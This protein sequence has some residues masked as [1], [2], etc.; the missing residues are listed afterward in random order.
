MPTNE[1]LIKQMY[2][3]DLASKK[4]QLQQSYETADSEF[5]AAKEKNAQVTDQNLT[6]TAV[7][8]QKAAKNM[9]E[10]H[11]AQGLSSG[12]RAQARLSLENQA[13]ANM[14]ALRAAQQ[15]SDAEIERQ[16]ALL[17][18]DY[19]AAIAQAQ[20]DNDLQKAQALYEQA[21]KAEAALLA[22]QEAAAGLMAQ[23]GDYSGY[24]TLYGMT[25]AQIAQLSNAY[26]SSAEAAAQEAQNAEFERQWKLAKD[27]AEMGDD[28]YMNA[29]LVAAGMKTEEPV[30]PENPPRD[31]YTVT[32]RTGN[33]WVAIGNSRMTNAELDAAIASGQVKRVYDDTNK[34][35]AYQY[36]HPG[37]SPNGT[38]VTGN[39]TEGN[40]QG[41]SSQQL[42]DGR[43]DISGQKMTAAELIARI[44]AGQIIE[45]VD[46]ATGEH[47]Y[48]WRTPDTPVK[49]TPLGIDR[50]AMK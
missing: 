32:N 37:V 19:A 41:K 48:K 20:A 10:Y 17:A 2:D 45:T 27:M 6:R 16:R 25:D 50:V 4:S 14:T 44:N 11:N 42:P 31:G 35:V 21:Q 12:A 34:T 49:N 43:F 29:L 28:S 46:P 15:E 3:S 24:K 33:G 22:K 8:S 13:A 47:F 39:E 40:T 18:K 38:P 36:A 23:V 7:E 5:T 9:A 30:V 1:E 26:K